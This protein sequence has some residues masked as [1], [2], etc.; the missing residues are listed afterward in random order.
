MHSPPTTEHQKTFSD[1]KVETKTDQESETKFSGRDFK[2]VD[3]LQEGNIKLDKADLTG[4]LETLERAISDVS[5][6]VKTLKTSLESLKKKVRHKLNPRTSRK[7]PFPFL[8]LF[9]LHSILV[10][11]TK[12]SIF[13]L[14]GKEAFRLSFVFL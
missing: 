12:F 6:T 3:Q 5:N 1:L 11:P 14:R 10:L 4:Q 8:F 13:S 7:T 9:F 2:R